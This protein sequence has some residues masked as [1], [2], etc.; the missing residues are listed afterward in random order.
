MTD[1]PN[2]SRR[3]FWDID[4]DSI[5][6]QVHAQSVILRVLERGSFD[7]MIAIIRFY[8]EDRVVDE[9]LSAPQVPAELANFISVVFN[10]SLREFKCY[11]G[12]Q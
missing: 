2:I 10:V 7:D 5:D 4:F 6:F 9:V 11:S 8:G 1:K 3:A 12:N